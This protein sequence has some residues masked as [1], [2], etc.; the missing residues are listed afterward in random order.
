MSIP[1][2]TTH[3][4]ETLGAARFWIIPPPGQEDGTGAF[5]NGTEWVTSEISGAFVEKLKPVGTPAHRWTEDPHA[6]RYDGERAQLTMGDLTDDEL[7]N[8]AFMNYDSPLNVQALMDGRPDYHPPIV[9]MTAVKDRI[10]WLSRK[11]GES[12]GY[13]EFE[14]RCKRRL[15]DELVEAKQALA[16][17]VRPEPWGEHDVIPLGEGSITGEAYRRGVESGRKGGTPLLGTLANR[18]RALSEGDKV[19]DLW[20][21][22][23]VLD[24]VLHIAEMPTPNALEIRAMGE[25]NTYTLL[26][27]GKW[28]ASVRMN[29]EMTEV[30]Q[31]ALL[32][33]CLQGWTTL[34]PPRMTEQREIQELLGR[35]GVYGA[36]PTG[37]A[38]QIYNAALDRVSELNDI[39]EDLPLKVVADIS[40]G[41][42]HGVYAT[43]PTEVLFIS[44]DEDDISA[45]REELNDDEMY[46]DTDGQ[47]IAGWVK[48][49][50][51]GQDADAV[52][53]FFSQRAE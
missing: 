16:V 35:F 24:D 29:G 4:D 34:L 51:G 15:E 26:S 32:H 36:V 13:A 1:L 30:R 41:A 40:G 21:A 44:S 17:W 28:L 20:D 45:Q 18:I 46:V 7:A 52:D 6:G 2:G 39:K 5:F 38:T 12:L 22:M 48:T 49:S 9:W 31:T 10:R 37:V 43:V 3:I 50:M 8:G 11:L 53:H 19:P 14:R 33:A 27:D 25:A 47:M 42:L 23:K